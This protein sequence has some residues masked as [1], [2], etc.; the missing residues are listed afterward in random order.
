MK[1]LGSPMGGNTTVEVGVN[2]E[3]K[4][5]QSKLLYEMQEAR[6][7]I[8]SVEPVIMAIVQKKQKNISVTDQQM[9]NVRQL[10]I[11]RQIKKKELENIYRRLDELE[12]I[13]EESK[14]PSVE[15]SE[16][17]YAGTKICILDVSLVVKS[18]ARYCKFIRS[19]GEVKMTA[20]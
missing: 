7:Y 3:L 19:E 10:A 20:L 4:K 8:A 11:S 17:V 6:K 15:I 12:D 18:N 5:L 9:K 1:S 2:P 16:S 14:V 13:L